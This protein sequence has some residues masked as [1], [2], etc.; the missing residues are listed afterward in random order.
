MPIHDSNEM[1][2]SVMYSIISTI[3]L[4]IIL[5]FLNLASSKFTNKILTWKGTKIRPL[6]IR[7]LELLTADRLISTLLG[8][9]QA[10]RIFFTLLLLYFYIPLVFSFFPWTEN[11]VPILLHYVTDPLK[12]ISNVIIDYIPK[13]FI[14]IFV[15]IIT[16]YILQFIK[17]IFREIG[18]GTIH[19][20]G[21]YKDWAEPSYKLVRI[22]I[23]AFSLIIIF[24]YLP[25]SG[26]PA[27][28][29]ISVFLGILFSLGSS[30]A[31]ANMVSGIVLTY[32]MPFKVGDRVKIS[33][34]VGD[35]IEK[36]LLVIRVRTIKNEDIT[37]PSSMV[38]GS[39]IINYSSSAQSYGLILNTT[40]SINYDTPWRLVHS[41]LTD[42]ALKT[43]DILKE[44]KPFVLQKEFNDF[45][46]SYEINAYTNQPNRMADIYSELRQNI[47][48]IFHEAKIEIMSPHYT[49]FRNGDKNA[50]STTDF[51]NGFLNQR[52]K[53]KDK[54]S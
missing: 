31:V 32:M 12:V 35:V 18:S 10:L 25:G 4:L 11:Y 42:A 43:N 49:A 23:L 7:N 14:I 54:I 1:I 9:I 20:N 40:I 51:S 8:C 27:F 5:Y 13:I 36:N 34:T 47:Q 26:S 50:I 45:Y 52:A 6:R 24:P 39:H 38:L 41:L 17:F 28:Q 2:F 21:F 29:G 33:S 44:P 53:D 46:V 15:A 30:S 3:L 19:I 37:I 22:L 48:D 16:K